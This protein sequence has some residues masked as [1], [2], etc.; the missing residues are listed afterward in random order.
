[1]LAAHS[2]N[3]HPT[4]VIS[5]AAQLAPDVQVGP[6]VVI[7][8]PVTLGAGCVVRAHA[9]L[10]GRIVAG[11]KND[12]GTGCVIG[13]RP[14]HTAYQGEETGVIIGNSNT[15]REGVTV[16]RGMPNATVNTRIGDRNLFMVNSHVGHDCVVGNDVVLVNG[17]LLGGH[18]TV[19]DRVLLSGNVGVH[20]FCRL[21]RLGM[22]RGLSVW[23]MDL[24][25]FF[26]GHHI[27][28]V[29]GVNVVGM[30]RAG[31]SAREIQAVRSAYKMLYLSG[32]L[33]RDAVAR[34]D[35]ELGEFSTV[36]ELIQFIRT[37]KRGVPGPSQYRTAIN[38][39]EHHSRA[40]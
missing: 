13:D 20:Q 18:V 4:A 5:S 12:F 31:I 15:F 6:F 30:R 26:L 35:S 27:N 21:G 37:T 36:Q 11:T 25:P 1:M 34:M 32:L 14:Q 38:D 22:L 19:G 16:H 10:T 23:S 17:C 33:I 29:A 40:A 3:I 8:G 28:S 7:D 9:H 2:A 24:P 39:G